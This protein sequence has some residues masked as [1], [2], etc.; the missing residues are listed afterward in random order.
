M[1]SRLE[2]H[3][4]CTSEP[5]VVPSYRVTVRHSSTVVGEQ[6]TFFCVGPTHK[7][8]VPTAHRPSPVLTWTSCFGK[9]RA[10]SLAL[11]RNNVLI[12]RK[13][14][15][16]PMDRKI[17]PVSWKERPIDRSNCPINWRENLMNQRNWL[18]HQGGYLVKGPSPGIMVC[19]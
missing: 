7:E 8:G 12:E 16:R 9:R 1:T 13:N 19:Q 4:H 10:S 18:V 17:R 11:L 2:T 5:R 15:N 14:A 6:Y 3:E